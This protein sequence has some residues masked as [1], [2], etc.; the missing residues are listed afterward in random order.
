MT[1][2]AL[3]VYGVLFA[4]AAL[5]VWRR[6][7]AALYVF[8][9]GLA[10]H[11]LVMAL[12]YGAG[13]HGNALEAIQAW[14]EGLLALAAARVAWDAVRARRWPFRP[15]AIDLLALAFGALIL[16]YAVLPQGG[17]GGHRGLRTA[18][19]Y[20]SVLSRLRAMASWRAAWPPASRAR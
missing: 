1:A 18:E 13:V 7:I 6:P 11:N 17:L 20:T 12:L 3:A 15:G 8:V 14:K 16:L 2:L 19:G 4:G 9:V 5:V 10:A